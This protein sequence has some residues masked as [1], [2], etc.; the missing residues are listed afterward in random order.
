MIIVLSYVKAKCICVGLFGGQ[1][2]Q[3]TAGTFLDNL[4]ISGLWTYLS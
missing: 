2:F 4:P 1:A 3:G